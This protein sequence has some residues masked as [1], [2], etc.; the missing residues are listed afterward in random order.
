MDDVE[1]MFFQEN[2]GRIQITSPK[3][4]FS[5]ATRVGRSEAP[6]HVQSR[7]LILDGVGYTVFVD[8]KKLHI[9][10]NVHMIITKT[11]SKAKELHPFNRL[12][13]RNGATS[14]P[15]KQE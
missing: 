15:A 7:T 4:A 1:L 9:R 14:K 6:I 3:C 2:G 10:S 11:G 8:S 13:R 12:S 5:E